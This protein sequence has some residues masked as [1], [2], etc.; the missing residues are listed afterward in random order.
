MLS[1]GWGK[2]K[3]KAKKILGLRDALPPK[4]RPVSAFGSEANCS[5]R[6]PLNCSSCGRR[7]HFMLC[8]GVGCQNHGG[9]HLAP[10]EVG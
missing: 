2:W 10:K 6:P 7:P 9:G 5:P 3:L 4:V 8:F 1:L